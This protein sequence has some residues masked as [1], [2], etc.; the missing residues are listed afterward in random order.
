M[1]WCGNATHH[2][3]IAVFAVALSQHLLV[4]IIAEPVVNSSALHALLHGVNYSYR[5]QHVRNVYAMR[6][7]GVLTKVL[8]V[9]R[10][11]AL[12]SRRR[13]RSASWTRIRLKTD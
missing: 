5:A 6:V 4:D 11:G 13:W 10:N 2:R 12:P 8:L 7:R 9:T 1:V 3:H